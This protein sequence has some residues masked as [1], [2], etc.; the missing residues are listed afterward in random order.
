MDLFLPL[1]FLA[2]FISYRLLSLSPQGHLGQAFNFFLYDSLK[3]IILLVLVNYFMAIVR[4]YLPITSIKTILTSRHWYGLDYFLAAVFGVVTPFCS[5]SSIPLFVG[6]VSSGVPLGVTL[7][8]LITSPLVNEASLVIF[9]AMF[10][11]KFTLLYNLSGILVGVLGGLVIQQFKLERYLEPTLLNPKSPTTSSFLTLKKEKVPL[12]L[13]WSQSWAITK[14]LI[15]YILLGIAI[16]ALIHGYIP[17][18]FFEKYLVGNSWW[19][20]PLATLLG[21]PFYANS[22]GIIPIMAS[23]IGKGIPVGTILAFTTATVTL[24]IPEALILKKVMK[25]PL[26]LVFFGV[27]TLGIMV[28]GFLFNVIY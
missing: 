6:F 3:I 25:P 12:K 26:L 20:V 17:A 28:L 21:V 8:F 27:T 4:H 5:C 1:Q 18:N 2:N 16:G 22:M 7:A 19:S 24:S 9:P 23:L 10:G 14:S 11:L 13:W 15:P